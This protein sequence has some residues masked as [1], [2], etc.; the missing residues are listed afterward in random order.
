MLTLLHVHLT[1]QFADCLQLGLGASHHT[2]S[3]YPKLNACYFRIEYML[4]LIE[5]ILQQHRHKNDKFALRSD[6]RPHNDM[7]H[8]VTV[9]MS[10]IIGMQR[11]MPL[12]HQ[13]MMETASC[14]R[15]DQE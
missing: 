14:S 11:W 2:V 10:S 4:F 9:Q 6:S 1:K 7:V 13:S 12:K 8:F 15:E 3:C 5:C